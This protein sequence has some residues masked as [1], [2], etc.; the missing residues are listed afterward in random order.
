LRSPLATMST[1]KLT[2]LITGATQGIGYETVRQLSKHAHVYV[3]LS[4]RDPEQV[5]QALENLSKEDGCKAVI[6]SVIIDVS[7]DKSIEAAVKEVE[8]KLGDAALDVLVVSSILS[9]VVSS[10]QPMCRTTPV[11]PKIGRSPHVA[12]AQFS[13]KYSQSTSLVQR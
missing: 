6:D 12:C 10:N 3:F 13:R 9:F 1:P 5:Q 8:A 2:I 11:S 7:D 4:G